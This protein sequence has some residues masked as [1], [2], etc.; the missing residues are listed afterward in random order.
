MTN[1]KEPGTPKIDDLPP[2]VEP[3]STDEADSVAGGAMARRPVKVTG[4][5]TRLSSG[6]PQDVGDRPDET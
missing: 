2:G 6:G 1:S 5:S 3:L 4:D